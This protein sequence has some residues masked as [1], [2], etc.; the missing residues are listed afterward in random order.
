M[1]NAEVITI[2]R[3]IWTIWEGLLLV[4]DSWL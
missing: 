1:W 4:K 2:H 3:L